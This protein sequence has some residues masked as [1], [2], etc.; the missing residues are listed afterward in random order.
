MNVICCYNVNI[1]SVCA[2]GGAKITE[3]IEKN[4]LGTEIK[5]LVE[6]PPNRINITSDLLALLL[7]HMEKGTGGEF[8]VETPDA[9]PE[10]AIRTLLTD[11]P[12]LR[13]GGN[14]G[15]AADV[16]SNLGASLVIPNVACPSRKQ[17]DLFSGEMIRIPVYKDGDISLLKPGDTVGCEEDALHY[18]F[19]FK[20]GDKVTLCGKTISVPN[21]NRIIA[22]YDPKNISLYMDD[23]FRE[24]S[25]AHIKEMDG[26]LI[27]GFHLLRNTYPDGS[28][29]IDC[30]QPIIDHLKRW[31]SINPN[32]RIHFESGDFLDG[33]IT[34]FIITR[35]SEIVDSIGMNEEEFI[36]DDADTSARNIIKRSVKLISELGI[37]RLCI[38]TRDF[39][40]SVFDPAYI[41]TRSE[42]DAL[43]F[44]ASASGALAMTGHADITSAHAAIMNLQPSDA[45]VRECSNVQEYFHGE[46][47]NGG[48]HL[49]LNGYS[50]CVAPSLHC[51]SPITTVGMGDTMTAG[52]F[53]REL[54]HRPA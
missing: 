37:S 28:T 4:D 34:D 18:V 16:L 3:Y 35:L 50:V 19:D 51:E 20:K 2:V 15:I 30:L 38:H 44:G 52:V 49:Q 11:E 9:I 8:L 32:F 23:A 5:H 7:I 26:A 47:V 42:I 31:K 53:L 39:I 33:S 14:A 36:K 1:D 27:S 29:Y 41:D 25:L 43:N 17:V 54:E 21:N 22:T 6:N 10:S 46:P 45:G 13:L 24:Y 48:V 12:V 40:V